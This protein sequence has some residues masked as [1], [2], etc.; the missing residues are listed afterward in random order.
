MSRI[1]DAERYASSPC[2]RPTTLMQIQ[3]YVLCVHMDMIE[4]FAL[5]Q[6]NKYHPTRPP[7]DHGNAARQLQSKPCPEKTSS[8]PDTKL[9]TMPR[10][11]VWWVWIWVV[12]R[13]Q[14][15]QLE[16]FRISC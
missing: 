16:L 7:I 13:H 4:H 1:I 3:P 9:P 10:F 5:Y 8:V 11:E 12:V 15:F 6:R 14:S 2:T